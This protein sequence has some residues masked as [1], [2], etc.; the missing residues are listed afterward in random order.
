M[1]VSYNCNCFINYSNAEQLLGTILK[2][3]QI[4]FENFNSKKI[5]KFRL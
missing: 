1:I 5:C 4:T 3:G 2:Q